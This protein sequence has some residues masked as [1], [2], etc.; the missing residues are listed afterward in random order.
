MGAS[1]GGPMGGGPMGPMGGGPMGG[2]MPM[3]MG[4]PM[5]MPPQMMMQHMGMP[6]PNQPPMDYMG[7]QGYPPPGRKPCFAFQR[8]E[9]MNGDN[10]RFAHVPGTGGSTFGEMRPSKKPCFNFNRNG[11]CE[12]GDSCRFAHVLEGDMPVSEDGNSSGDGRSGGG[13]YNNMGGSPGG[14]GGGSVCF[15]FQR[16]SCTR[17]ESCRYPHIPAHTNPPMS[18]CAPIPS[19]AQV[20]A[21]MAANGYDPNNGG[22]NY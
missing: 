7:Y 9:C 17:G 1:M 20:Q 14:G 12:R 8:G 15:A 21:N 22:Y 18:V 6:P 5:G 19:T 2:P 10:C 4:M 11:H 16:G 3:Q 13:G